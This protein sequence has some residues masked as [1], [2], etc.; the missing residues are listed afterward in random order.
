ML[1]NELIFETGSCYIAVAGLGLRE[2]LPLPSE[3]WDQQ[4]GPLHGFVVVVLFCLG[5]LFC[6]VFAAG[7]QAAWVETPVSF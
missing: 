3:C 4:H 1:V 2:I 6:F 5:F 7:C